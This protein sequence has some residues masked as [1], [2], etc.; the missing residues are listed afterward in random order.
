MIRA[1]LIL[2]TIC[3]VITAADMRF[4][5][6]ES[7]T[8]PSSTTASKLAEGRK[9]PYLTIFSLRK[10]NDALSTEN[11]ELQAIVASQQSM[12]DYQKEIIAE[13]EWRLQRRPPCA[14]PPHYTDGY[15]RIDSSMPRQLP[16]PPY[17]IGPDRESTFGRNDTVM[18][19]PIG[20]QYERNFRTMERLEN[21]PL[22][23]EFINQTLFH[24]LS[25]KATDPR[26]NV[27]IKIVIG[28]KIASEQRGAARKESITYFQDAQKESKN[29]ESLKDLWKFAT[30][31]LGLAYC[32]NKQNLRG[33]LE[34]YSLKEE[35]THFVTQPHRVGY[36]QKSLHAS[37]EA[38]LKE[39]DWLKGM[40]PKAQEKIIQEITEAAK[41]YGL[42]QE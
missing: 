33:L 42:T 14:P 37:W 2:F 30:I 15:S 4:V 31:G 16:P 35:T 5:V 8:Y 22:Y 21:Y 36:F 32:D 34:L 27:M 7:N 3:S 28:R 19:H 11:D 40:S 25:L 23:K 9:N 13:L 38:A 1:I 10:E 41:F 12:I 20:N 18:T 39:T 24:L 29:D 17:P 6:T 26:R